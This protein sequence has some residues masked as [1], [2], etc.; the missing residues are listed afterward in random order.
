MKINKAYKTELAPNKTQLT[1]LAKSV[2]TARFVWNWGLA[3]RIEEYKTTGKSSNAIDQHRQLNQ[4]KQQEEYGWLYEV[5]KCCGQEALRDLDKAYANFFRRVKNKDGKAGHP[6]FKSKH[7]SKQSF[8]LAGSIS[9]TESRVHLPRIGWVKLKEKNYIPVD[10]KALSATVSKR[11]NRWFVSILTEEEIN[12]VNNAEGRVVG[13]DLGIKVLAT[14]SDNVVYINPK[15]LN[16]NLKK[17]ARLQ[18]QHSRKVKG[19]NNRRKHISKIQRVHCR[20]SCIR[21]D[22]IHQM[23]TAVAKTKPRL[24]VIEDLAV[25]NMMRNHKLARSLSDVA[26]GETRRQFEYKGKWYGFEVMVADRYYPSSKMCS[27]CGHIKVELK[28]SD[29]IFICPVCGLVIDRDLNASINLEQYPTQSSWGSNACGDECSNARHKT[30]KGKNQ[31]L[32]TIEKR[33]S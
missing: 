12:P 6:K 3:L 26:F 27:R 14:T 7:D 15:A 16:K 22:A 29:R 33:A 30:C 20:V 17:L 8:R 24:V 31:E 23:T 19:S 18:K 1:L 2:G 5:S 25:K 4:L 28:L 10:C 21:N 9:A 13:I 11:A 32:K